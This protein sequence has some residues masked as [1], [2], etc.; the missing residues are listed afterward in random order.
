MEQI[1]ELIEYSRKGNIMNIKGNY[2]FYQFKQLKELIGKQNITKDNNNKN[3][4][5]HIAL[6][7][8]YTTIINVT[9]N[10]G[11]NTPHN[12]PQASA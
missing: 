8:K 9:G 2:Y 1:M 5:L 11:I 4:I 7:Y 3:N 6:R 12:I 10:R